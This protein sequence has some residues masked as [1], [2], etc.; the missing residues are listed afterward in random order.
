MTKILTCFMQFIELSTDAAR[1][2]Q[3]KTVSHH[4]LEKLLSAFNNQTYSIQ[5]PKKDIFFPNPWGSV[6]QKPKSEDHKMMSQGE[7]RYF[8]LE[9]IRIRNLQRCEKIFT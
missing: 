5:F 1:S 8:T 9:Q 3:E 4:F 7:I 6:S 2:R